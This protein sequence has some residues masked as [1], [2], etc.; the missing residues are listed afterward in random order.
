MVLSTH[1]LHKD[2]VMNPASSSSCPIYAKSAIKRVYGRRGVKWDTA[3]RDGSF[4]TSVPLASSRDNL[5]S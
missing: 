2:L 4:A 1:S 5:H 3:H